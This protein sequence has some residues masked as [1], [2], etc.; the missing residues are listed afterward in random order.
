METTVDRARDLCPMQSKNACHRY[1]EVEA[2]VEH[3][4]RLELQMTIVELG[5]LFNLKRHQTIRHLRACD[6]CLQQWLLELRSVQPPY[7]QHIEEILKRS[8]TAKINERGEIMPL[9][10]YRMDDEYRQKMNLETVEALEEWV[11]HGKG[12]AE[13]DLDEWLFRLIAGDYEKAAL[14]AGKA[15]LSAFGWII[16]C[17]AMDFPGTCFG[18]YDNVR[19][20]RGLIEEDETLVSKD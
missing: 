13:F 8:S 11:N 4:T 7:P 10:P 1:H 16:R 2:I 14:L 20:W 19:A 17:M 3:P 6:Q 18:S 15:Q 5:F 9:Y 12:E